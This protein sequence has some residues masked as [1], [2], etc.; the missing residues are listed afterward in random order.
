MSSPQQFP[1]ARTAAYLAAP[2]WAV[3]ALVWTAGPKVQEQAAPYRIT[4]TVLFELFWLSVA[5]AV[6]FSA[7]AALAIPTYLRARPTRMVRTGSVLARIAVGLAGLAAL[8][9]AVAPAPRLQSAALTVLTNALYGATLLLA[10]SLTLY[11]LAGRTQARSSGVP[12]LLPAALA[13]LT[14]VT[15]VAILASGTASTVGLY[16]AV[17]VVVINGMAWFAWGNAL[18]GTRA[19]PAAAHA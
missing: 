12:A 13:A 11:A 2:L 7:V 19:H 15:I 14:V 4:N 18:A 6:A 8:S 9:V 10:I 5:A 17:T 1:I 3:Q 16:F